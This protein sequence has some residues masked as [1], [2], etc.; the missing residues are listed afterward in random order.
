[1]GGGWG[2]EE[3]L[4][5]ATVLF[6][7]TLYKNSLHL[8]C[9]SDGKTVIMG[10]VFTKTDNSIGRQSKTKIK[11]QFRYDIHKLDVHIDPGLPNLTQATQEIDNPYVRGN[12]RHRISRGIYEKDLHAQSSSRGLDQSPRGRGCCRQD[13]GNQTVTVHQLQFAG[14]Y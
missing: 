14:D 7:V 12:D 6:N 9:V 11:V 1:M 4:F 8:T 3:E 2:T 5:E 13:K 10:L